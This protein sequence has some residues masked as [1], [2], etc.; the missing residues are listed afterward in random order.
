MCGMLVRGSYQIGNCLEL[1]ERQLLGGIWEGSF[2]RG[3]QSLPDSCVGK[4]SEH[5]G[6]QR[7]ADSLL[8]LSRAAVA[9]RDG[10]HVGCGANH[11]HALGHHPRF[12]HWR[13]V[14][15]V[16]KMVEN[17]L[18][19]TRGYCSGSLD[20]HDCLAAPLRVLVSHKHHGAGVPVMYCFEINQRLDSG[21]Q[22]RH[23]TQRQPRQDGMYDWKIHRNPMAPEA[24][25]GLFAKALP[26]VFSV[27]Q[28]IRKIE[29][30]ARDHVDRHS[31]EAMEYVEWYYFVYSCVNSHAQL[32]HRGRDGI[33]KSQNIA[34]REERVE[35]GT[36]GAVKGVAACGK[37]RVR[38]TE[39]TVEGRVFLEGGANAIDGI[40]E[41][42]V[43]D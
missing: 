39:A 33:F 3:M 13:P 43:L 36:H 31:L 27:E 2:Q 14:R 5:R 26:E 40:V 42:H 1:Q 41:V 20:P 24:C 34:P 17:R 7:P 18:S 29:G 4:D 15:D 21:L 19:G 30:E 9:G 23:H 8:K 10:T 11:D 28:V 22:H 6:C 35:G 37:H 25:L 32:T 12:R 38:D 16:Q